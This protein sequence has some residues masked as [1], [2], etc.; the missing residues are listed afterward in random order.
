MA[1]AKWNLDNSDRY[2]DDVSPNSHQHTIQSQ[3]PHHSFHGW[4]WWF[5]NRDFDIKCKYLDIDRWSV[6]IFVDIYSDNDAHLNL[7]SHGVSTHCNVETVCWLTHDRTLSDPVCGWKQFPA[8]S[9]SSVPLLAGVRWPHWAAHPLIVIA[10]I[11]LSIQT[12]Y[13]VVA[14]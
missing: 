5:L 6:D 11:C 13:A 2:F 3:S 8:D 14:L 9:V 7:S 1:A 4:I 12:L 10:R